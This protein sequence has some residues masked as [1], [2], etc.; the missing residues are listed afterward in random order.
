MLC[1]ESL[2]NFAILY[3]LKHYIWAIISINF[4]FLPLYQDNRLQIKVHRI[5]LAN[6]CYAFLSDKSMEGKN[7]C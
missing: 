6:N 5:N 7:P 2:K 3:K 4:T 1:R